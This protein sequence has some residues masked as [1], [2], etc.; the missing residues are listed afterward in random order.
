MTDGIKRS[1][2]LLHFV[3]VVD[4]QRGMVNFCCE[5]QPLATVRS[6]GL[7]LRCPFCRLESPLGHAEKVAR[8]SGV[9]IQ[10][11]RLKRTSRRE[12]Q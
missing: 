12:K 4:E 2:H 8:E 7:P 3:T 10:I 5:S 11:S 9:R 6:F 1:N